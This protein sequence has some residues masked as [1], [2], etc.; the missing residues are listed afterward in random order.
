MK[1]GQKAEEINRCLFMMCNISEMRFYMILPILI[2]TYFYCEVLGKVYLYTV[3]NHVLHALFAVLT[4]FFFNYF[5]KIIIS[6]IQY[7]SIIEKLLKGFLEDFFC[8]GQSSYVSAVSFGF[9]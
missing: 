1:F 9:P 8:L 3:L 5:H 7:I 4:F 6:N 2:K